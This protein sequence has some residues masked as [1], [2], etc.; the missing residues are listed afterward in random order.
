[1]KQYGQYK[2]E[3]LYICVHLSDTAKI[4]TLPIT[5][6]LSLNDMPG[7]GKKNA[8]TYIHYLCWHSI[9][10]AD[11]MSAFHLETYSVM[12]QADH[13]CWKSDF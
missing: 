2:L 1:M 10:I 6:E 4:T 7:S 3:I 9:F 13:R 8:R 11:T 5:G 12:Y